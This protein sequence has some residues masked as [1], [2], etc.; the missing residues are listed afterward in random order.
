MFLKERF[1]IPPYEE[2]VRIATLLNKFD[3]LVSDLT[4]G[5]PAEMTAVQELY[6]YYRNKLLSFPRSKISA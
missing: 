1:P 5:L 3:V 6:E 2:Q 4:E